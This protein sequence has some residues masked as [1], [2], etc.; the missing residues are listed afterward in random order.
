MSLYT[1][2]SSDELLSL[3][4]SLEDEFN[5]IKSLNLSLDMS[6]GKPSPKQLDL[7]MDMLNCLEADDI[8][9]TAPDVRNYGG[10]EGLDAV[11]ELFGEILGLNKDEVFVGGNSS[12][13]LMYDT[14]VK[15]MLFGFYNSEKPW[16]KCEKLKFLCPVPGYD[17]HFAITETL[18][19]EMINVPM[20]EDG[21]DMDIVEKLVSSDE[22]IKGIWCV[23]MYSNPEGITYSDET[24][25]RFANLKPAAKDFKIFWDNA[26]CIH[27]INDSHDTLLN[28]MD[29]CKKAGTEDSVLIFASTSKITFSGAGVAVFG[30]SVNNIKHLTK[31]ISLQTIGYDK[32]NQLRH[33]KFFKNAD[34]IFAHM[35]KH[36]LIIK[37]KFEVVLKNLDEKIKDLGIAYWKVP[38]GG[39]FISLNVLDGCAK[40]VVSLCKEAG[41]VLTGA[42]ATFPYGL[43]P[44]DKN[45]RIAPTFPSLDDLQKATE[46]LCLAIKLASVE[47]LLQN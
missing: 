43:D 8:K 33:L 35:K 25:R 17:R 16:S 45:I 26:Y 13:N 27:H 37:P 20:T 24:V 31:H 9:N 6:R 38:N 11:R 44:N 23:P 10:L 47:K 7:S 14:L 46:V 36:A 1:E 5:K 2:L 4:A 21:P 40:R 34:G 30:A 41:V 18:G 12:L 42:G 22:A 15:A 3:K 32:V 28:L 29:E 19:F 39:Y